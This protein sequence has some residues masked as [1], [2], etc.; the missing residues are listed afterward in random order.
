V[1]IIYGRG[2]L[3]HVVELYRALELAQLI[4][5]MKPFHSHKWELRYG[6]LDVYGRRV[7]GIA[8]T[9]GVKIGI[10]VVSSEKAIGEVEDKLKRLIISGA[11]NEGYVYLRSLDDVL[12]DVVEKAKSLREVRL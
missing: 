12:R 8:I 11:I 9:G 10:E 2:R 5:Y 6:E 7:D 4:T 3:R 1:I